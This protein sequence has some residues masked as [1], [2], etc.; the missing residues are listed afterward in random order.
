LHVELLDAGQ[1][2]FITPSG[3]HWFVRHLAKPYQ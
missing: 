2:F 1:I 3:D